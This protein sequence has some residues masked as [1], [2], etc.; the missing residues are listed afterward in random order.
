VPAPVLLEPATAEASEHLQRAFGLTLRFGLAALLGSV[1]WLGTNYVSFRMISRQ[2]GQAQAGGFYAFQQLG[3]LI[4]YLA[5]AAWTVVF[6]HV[7]RRWEE[8][9]RTTAM[10]TLQTAYKAVSLAVTTCCIFAYSTKGLWIHLLP[11]RYHQG[12]PLLGGLLMFFQVLANLSLTTMLANLHRRPIIIALAALVGGALNAVLA[13]RWLPVYGPV[14][15][16]WAAGIGMYVG[17][18]FVTAAYLLLARIRLAA[19]TLLVFASPAIL[20]L[21]IL[22]WWWTLPVI[23]SIVLMTTSFTHWLFSRREKEILRSY[24]SGFAEWAKRRFA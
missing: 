4:L 9:D 3:Q 16:A 13:G 8:N 19:N 7:A 15:A 14:G 21:L 6:A 22:P 24:L 18:A 5:N 12:L 20:I 2:L 23:W 17:A 1:L 11:S 10:F